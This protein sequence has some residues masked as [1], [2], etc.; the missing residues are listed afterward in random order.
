MTKKFAKYVNIYSWVSSVIG[1]PQ[2]IFR[3][4]VDED[5]NQ[6]VQIEQNYEALCL[7]QLCNAFG[8][9][10]CNF[11]ENVVHWMKKTAPAYHMLIAN[12]FYV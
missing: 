11:N 9:A 2:Q 3:V 10:M 4:Y 7:V 1:Q 12:L 5:S 6:Y 8:D